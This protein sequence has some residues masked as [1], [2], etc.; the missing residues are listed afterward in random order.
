MRQNKK[1]FVTAFCLILSY[2]IIVLP[3]AAAPAAGDKNVSADVPKNWLAQVQQDIVA[4]EYHISPATHHDPAIGRVLQASNR[5][6]NL[7]TWFTSSGVMVQRRISENTPWTFKLVPEAA[8]VTGNMRKLKFDKP[9][10]AGNRVTYS[11]KYMDQWFE[12]QPEGLEQGFTIPKPLGDGEL[13]ITLN[14]EGS[15]KPTLKNTTTINLATPKGAMNLEYGNLQVVDAGKQ[16]LPSRFSLAGSKLTIH[17]DTCGAAYPLTVDPL[18]CSVAWQAEGDQADAHFGFSVSTAGDVNNDGYDDVIIGAPDFDNGEY[19]EGA[20]FVYLGSVA[21]LSDTPSWQAEGDQA[22]AHFGFSVSTAGDVNNDGYDDV[23][24]GAWAYGNGEIDEGAAFVYLGSVAGLAATPLWQA[25]GD[26]ADAHFGFS[27]STAG[28]VNNDGYDDV[29]IGA[30]DFDFG[31]YNEGAAFVYLG[32]VAGLATSPS[33]QAEGGQAYAHFGCSVSTAGDVNNDGYDDVIIGVES[34]DNG[35]YD[36]GAAF[37]Y[38]GSVAGLS[39]TPSWQAEGNQEYAHF[40]DSVS[41][42]GDVNNDGYDDVIIGVPDFDNGEIDEGAAFVYL[43]SVAGLAATPSWQ[44]EGDQADA[45]FGFSVSTAGDVNNDGYDDVIIGAPDFDN[46][47]IDEGAAFVYLGSVAGLAATPS[48]QAEGDQANAHF[49]FSVSTAGD[50][51]NDGYD[52]VIIGAWAY[53]NGESGEGAAFVYLGS[54][55]TLWRAEG[56]QV[57]AWFGYSVSFAGDVNNDGYDDVIVGAPGYSNGELE[58]GAAFVYLGSVAGLQC[59]VSWQA[60][61]DQAHASFGKSVSTA[62]DINNDGYDDVIVG[63][64]RYDNGGQTD[65]GMVYVYLG[66]ADGLSSIPWTWSPNQAYAY[67]GCSVSTA[68]DINNDGYDDV[69]VGAQY[70]D[71]GE[72]DEGAAFIFPGTPT[73][74]NS[75]FLWTLESN[76]AG[77]LFGRSVSSA[78]DVNNDGFSDVIIGAP[79]YSNVENHEGALFVWHGSASGPAGLPL[80]LE[81]NQADAEF[82]F[83]VSSAG[84]VNNDGYNDVIVGAPYYDNG[85]TDEGMAFLYAGGAGGL[86]FLP[87]WQWESNQEYANFGFSV[88]TAGDVNNDGYDDVIVGAQHFDNIEVNEGVV[89]VFLGSADG[90]GT[91]PAWWAEGDQVDAYFGY[92]VSLAGDVNNDGYDDVIVGALY[93]DNGE[94]NEGAAFVYYGATAFPI[95]YVSSNGQCGFHSPCYSSL[96]EA[97]LRSVSGQEIWATAESYSENLVFDKPVTIVLSGGWDSDFNGNASGQTSIIGTLTIAA[98]IVTVSNIVI[99]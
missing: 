7:R 30:P 76:N 18:L 60:E 8:G 45:Y 86:W 77:A 48:W 31:E 42:A 21:G 99:E 83:F 54:A 52:D 38:L 74:L 3:V 36:E 20:A 2:L 98:G 44:A 23:I 97:Y 35:E 67:F 92:S 93:Y 43:G 94:A 17:I 64:Y 73:G 55:D 22:D 63:A 90:L 47:E 58:E 85:Q 37:V 62:G 9:Q 39:A 61:G 12:N 59:L 19:N 96:G 11:G 66:S 57:A 87:V 79:W 40:G 70:Y 88:S 41:T 49:G 29:I 33:W 78:G 71:N 72:T 32:S 28:D 80:V 82:G 84:D 10:A 24:I 69:I 34:F 27:V 16:T 1:I 15:F 14:V 81:S 89:G 4:R 56:D 50:V 65:A 75:N 6:Q 95:L 91:F 68:G 13:L 46:G 25:E 53:G 51:N 5:R 26:Q